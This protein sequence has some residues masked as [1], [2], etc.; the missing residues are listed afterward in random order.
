MPAPYIRKTFTSN[1]KTTAT[2]SVAACGFYEMF[3]NGKNVT[4]GYF[5][6][7]ISNT[8]DY[9]YYDNYEIDIDEGENVLAFILGNGLQNNPSGYIWDLGGAKVTVL[10]SCFNT[11]GSECK[12]IY[13]PEIEYNEYN[14]ENATSVS[15]LLNYEGFKYYHGAD[16][17][18]YTQLRNLQDFK[19]L[20]GEDEL[21]CDYFYANNHFHCDLSVEFIKHLN[22]AVVYIP[23][24]QAL[25]SRSTYNYQ[26][27]K[28][29]LNTDGIRLRDTFISHA[30]GSVQVSVKNKDEWKYFTFK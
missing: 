17:Y 11:D 23:A 26:Y 15:L 29:F 22:P 27:L 9:I 16:N 20:G 2:I 8:D 30:N 4:K 19:K 14:Y 3:I 5:A 10:N 7:Y 24:N 13:D 21:K 12:V 28:E 25:Y 1:I 6:P 18:S